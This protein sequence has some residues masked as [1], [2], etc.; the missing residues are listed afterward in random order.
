MP[1]W[2]QWITFG[3]S[4]MGS[5][6]G[7]WSFVLN[8]K[9]IKIN[10]QKEKERLADKKKA[11][12]RININMDYSSKPILIISNEGIASANN[13]KVNFKN[14]KSGEIHPYIG[15]IP[16]SIPGKN[17]IKLGLILHNGTSLPWD[18]DLTWDDEHE[19]G[20]TYSTIIS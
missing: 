9:N 15:N 5:L 2:I 4:V 7:V 20:R 10:L 13:I 6:F 8:R 16:N 17:K 14:K 19:I 3:L 18:V 1:E 11:N 12:M